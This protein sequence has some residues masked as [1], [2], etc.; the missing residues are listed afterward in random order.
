[1]ADDIEDEA[2]T[3]AG[4]REGLWV[5]IVV[6]GAVA[7]LAAR[8]PFA[9]SRFWAE[10]GTVFF[11]EALAEG[12]LSAFGN[13]Y[14]GYFH[15]LPRI[16]GALSSSVPFSSAAIV[17]WAVVAL[18]AGWC[19]ATVFVAS[20]T[21][22]G[23]LAGRL[24]LAGAIV[25]LPVLR[26]ESIA[27]MANLHFVLL[28]PS[29]L[30]TISK[31][32]SRAEWINGSAF[33]VASTLSTPQTAVLLPFVL[34]RLAS[35]RGVDSIVAS[36][37]AGTVVHFLAIAVV[38]PERSTD[39][40]TSSLASVVGNYGKRVVLDNFS[41]FSS[42]AAVLAVVLIVGIGAVIARAVQVD[43]QVDRTR[44]VLL[45]A[46][47]AAGGVLWLLL[48]VGLGDTTPRYAVF[49]AMC[50]TW[51]VLVAV[52]TLVSGTSGL[53]ASARRYGVSVVVI[54]I[55]L[56]GWLPHWRPPDFRSQGPTWGATVSSAE[57][58]CAEDD[59][60][61]IEVEVPPLTTEG[62]PEWP[63]VLSCDRVD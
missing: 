40:G 61:E 34:Y 36:W 57:R 6:I 3:V 27:N 2:R 32:T 44:A 18:L 50:L 52:E 42:P 23:S 46:V 29:L 35:R 47:P 14:A 20:K 24:L 48:G 60:A 1:M 19:A 5:V 55:V 7:L 31:P 22:L 56:V 41:P 9:I 58:A 11:Q 4:Q 49:P 26:Y 38:R 59:L 43:W 12:P 25:L 15:L 30:I 63:V 53:P 28:F 45:V 62:P 13:D 10:D 39:E 16:A 8:A 17:N 54:G 21:W 51:A 33:L 37:T